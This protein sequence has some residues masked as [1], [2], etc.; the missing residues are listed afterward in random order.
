MAETHD[1]LR[2]KILELFYEK[3][4]K[5][6]KDSKVKR[7]E[8]IQSLSVPENLVDFNAL[9][10]ANKEIPCLKITS[11]HGIVFIT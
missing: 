2:R 3:A 11:A 9:A 7:E 8:L 10:R 6:S 1:E 4:L 5:N